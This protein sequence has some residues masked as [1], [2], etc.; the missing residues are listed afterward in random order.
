MNGI[1]QNT[2]ATEGQKKQNSRF[3]EDAFQAFK[4]KLETMFGELDTKNAQRFLGNG[5]EFKAD[6]LKAILD[7]FGRLSVSDQYKDE[8]VD[9]SYAYPDVY[10]GLKPIGVQVDV[11]A[12]EFNLSLG[13]VSE[14][15]ENVLPTLPLPEGA[16]GWAA[17]PSVDAVAKRFFPE[18]TDQAE[19][20]CRAVELIL[21]KLGK[22]RNFYNYREGEVNTR[23]LRQHARTLHALDLIAETQK[24]DILIIPVQYG[25][26]HRGRSDRR[27]R[28]CF[29]ANEFG[30]GA[31]A[32]GCMAFTHPER[33]V[34]WEELDT[35]CPGDE[36]APGADGDFSKSPY[37]YFHGGKLRFGTRGVSDARGRFGAV[38]GFLPQ[39]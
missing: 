28:E 12:K 17:I 26:R 19:K 36:F 33:Y 32:V 2:P 30:F 24:G 23:Q 25:M 7:S 6:T 14:F 35:D 29:V 21:E 3:L 13:Y 31:F 22:T 20:Y 5:D 1:T 27:A 34:Q 38:S 4:T 37:L 15:I 16:E 18:V 39:G 8:E 11:L 9:S 10:H